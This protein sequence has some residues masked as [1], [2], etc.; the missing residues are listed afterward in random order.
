M[1]LL[2]FASAI[3]AADVQCFTTTLLF[4]LVG[5]NCKGLLSQACQALLGPLYR[6]M[7]CAIIC[8]GRRVC[9]IDAERAKLLGARVAMFNE[10]QPGEKL[11]TNEVQLLSGGDGIAACAKYC[12][13]IT[14]QPR[15]MCLL[16]TNHMPEIDEVIPAIVERLIC[17]HFPV[18]FTDLAEGEEETPIRRQKDVGLKDRLRSPDGKAAFLRWLV[19]GAMRWYAQG[20]GLR[21]TAPEAVRGFTKK[22][23]E[24]QDTVAKF[25][26][27]HCEVGEGFKVRSVDLYLKYRQEEDE[28]AGD[29]WFSE[30]MKKKGFEKKNVRFGEGVTKGYVG[31]E[32]KE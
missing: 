31:L 10:L 24:D 25:L 5:R 26:A 23:L 18:T 1:K 32:L 19:V 8:D 9:N 27:E 14:I 4:L 3:W 20:G 13:P 21:R 12:D 22:Y 6:E 15:H 7:N 28:K 30:Q 11:K 17:V 16:S 29:K 2:S